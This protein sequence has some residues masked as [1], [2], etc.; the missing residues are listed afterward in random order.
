VDTA[1]I[2]VVAVALCFLSAM[3]VLRMAAGGVT[4]ARIAVSIAELW[5]TVIIWIA[6]FYTIGNS[7]AGLA[8]SG[9]AAN[10]RGLDSL[11]AGVPRAARP[12]LLSGVAASLALAAHLMW[13]LSRTKYVG[14]RS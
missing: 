6:V 14:I 3:I 8:D 13:S 9:Q 5:L 12:W 1:F 2:I 4:S 11:L 7:T 10:L